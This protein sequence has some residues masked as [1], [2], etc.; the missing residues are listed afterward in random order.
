[1]DANHDRKMCRQ[2][3]LLGQGRF[4]LAQNFIRAAHRGK[5]ASK[6]KRVQGCGKIARIGVP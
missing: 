5:A 3:E 1:M 4:D 2:P 6:A